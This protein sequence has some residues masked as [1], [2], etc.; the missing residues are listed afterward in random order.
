MCVGDLEIWPKLA[1]RTVQLKSSYYVLFEISDGL[2]ALDHI[3]PII[4][5][6]GIRGRMPRYKLGRYGPHSNDAL[7]EVDSPSNII[8]QNMSRTNG[9]IVR[10]SR[11]YVFDSIMPETAASFTFA[12]EY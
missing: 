12:S 8:V 4:N 11:P 10:Y 5:D 9:N 3:Q 2:S 1:G 7:F 6:F